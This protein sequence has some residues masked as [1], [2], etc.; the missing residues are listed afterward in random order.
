LLGAVAALGLAGT[1]CADQSA[2]I[3]VG[4]DTV[5]E[6]DLVE[7]MN[8]LRDNEE[9]LRL[10]VGASRDQIVGEM[11]DDSYLQLF[12]GYTV[13][14]RVFYLLQHQLADQEGVEVSEAEVDELRDQLETELE[15][16]GADV[17]ELPGSLLDRLAED[18]AIG[19]A[20]QTELPAE[21]QDAFMEL[22]DET[23]V[24]LSSRFGEWDHEAFLAGLQGTGQIASA[25]TPPPA[26]RP[27]PGSEGG[28]DPGLPGG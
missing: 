15:G 17:A 22:A 2:A 13:V 8:A 27:A 25:V 23:E 26:P 20:L 1:G 9:A 5:S 7:E 10:I 28:T 18:F 16:A 11:G 12:A 19:Q 14:Q 4:D 21:L 6:Q 24:E 3:R